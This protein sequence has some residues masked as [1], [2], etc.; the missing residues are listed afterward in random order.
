M[1]SFEKLIFMIEKLISL[2]E[3]KKMFVLTFNFYFQDQPPNE[4]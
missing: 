3:I 1:T 4:Q 2:F